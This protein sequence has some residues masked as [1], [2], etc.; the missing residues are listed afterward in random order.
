MPDHDIFPRPVEKEPRKRSRSWRRTWSILA[1]C[2]VLVAL[3]VPVA[4][5]NAFGGEDGGEP[6]AEET[7]ESRLSA[8]S[9]FELDA[10]L[11]IVEMTHQGEGDFLV[12]L[13]PARQGEDA[14]APER[15]EFFGD[16]EGGEGTAF[17]LAEETGSVD[18]SRVVGIRTAGTHVFDVRA[19]GPWTIRVEQPRPSDA[20]QPA[21]FSGDDDTATPLFRLSGG[22]KEISV[23]NPSGG[24][25]EIS[26]LDVDGNEVERV[27]GDETY[28][29]EAPPA[30]FSSTDD[31]PEDGVCLFD[32]RAE[33]LWTVEISD[34]R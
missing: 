2:G 6:A 20:P 12:A 27:L 19:S 26:L 5:V 24:E 8:T 34:A 1:V 14:A 17:T 23:T 15:I 21:E 9:T 4:L 32:V 29:A 18:T 25:L 33:G 28:G 7:P 16:E 13:L 10:G 11:A 30:T 31:I 22:P 3:V